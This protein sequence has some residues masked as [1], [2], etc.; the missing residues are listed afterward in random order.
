[1]LPGRNKL[2]VDVDGKGKR[3][4]LAIDSGTLRLLLPADASA[5]QPPPQPPVPRD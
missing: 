5:A 3:Q 2:I 4:L 1:V